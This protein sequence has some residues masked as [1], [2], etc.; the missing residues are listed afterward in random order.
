MA[1]MTSD[2]AAVPAAEAAAASGTSPVVQAAEAVESAI[3]AKPLLRG[4]LH[5]GM[6]PAVIVAGLA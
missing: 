1:R 4:W 3:E 5:L 2:A 6:F